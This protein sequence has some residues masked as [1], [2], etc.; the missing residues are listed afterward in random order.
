MGY[1]FTLGVIGVEPR[2]RGET[3]K[4]GKDLERWIERN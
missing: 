1:S 3:G 2:T 4:G